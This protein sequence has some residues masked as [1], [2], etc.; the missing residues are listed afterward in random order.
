MRTDDL[1][2]YL[3]FLGASV[4]SQM[5][6]KMAF[7]LR[8]MAD[9]LIVVADFA[10]TYFLVRFFGGLEG[11]SLAE[12]ALFYGMVELSWAPVEGALHG[13]ENFGVCLIQGDLD[14]WLLRPRSLVL[15][16]ASHWFEIRKLGR[17]AQAAIVL[18]VAVWWLGF[19][20][21]ALAWVGLGVAGGILFFSGVVFFGAA[22][23]FWTLGQTSELQNMLTYGGSAALTYPVSIYSDWF[24]RVVTFG[25]PLA[26]VNY[27]PAL[28]ALGRVESDGWPPFV[29][30]LS[31]FV[32]LGVLLLAR[33][34][35]TRGVERYE[36]TGS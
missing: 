36:S 26:F 19:D 31:P 15:Q 22:S 6:Y 33:A 18:G 32:C 17:V 5:Q 14:R 10:P 4:R 25:V 30:W 1:R 11:W 9:L 13:F 24:R 29:P 2:L 7:A 23:H 27:F 20:L 28:A 34:A 12:L 8:S 16:V 35:F 21:R 3:D